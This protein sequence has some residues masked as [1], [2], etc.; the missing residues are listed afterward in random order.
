MKKMHLPN[1]FRSALFILT[2]L[3]CS[4]ISVIAADTAENDVQTAER[5]YM[6]QTKSITI[7]NQRDDDDE[8]CYWDYYYKFTPNTSGVYEINSTVLKKNRIEVTDSEGEYVGD[9]GWDQ[10]TNKVNVAVK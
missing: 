6:N 3:V 7:D 9:T 1:M 8:S 4:C 10:Y 2:M 5:I